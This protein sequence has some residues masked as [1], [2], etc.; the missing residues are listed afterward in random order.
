VRRLA[1]TIAA[2]LIAA[3]PA[4]A[5]WN[6]DGPGDVLA[7]RPD[8]KLL[9]YAGAG[10]GLAAPQAIGGDG[11]AALTAVMMPG[12][13]SG[14]GQPDVL[15]RTPQGEL[16]MYRG[17]GKGGWAGGIAQTVG[18]GWG[19]FTALVA[20]GD[21]SGDGLPDVL[22]RHSD[23][24][25]SMYRGDGDGGWITGKAEQIGTSWHNFAAVLPGGDFSGDGKPDVLVVGG[26]GVLLMYRGNGAGGWVTGKSEQIG[27]SGWGAFTALA[28][29]G[30]FSGDGKP[31]VL[32]RTSEGALLL[33]RGNGAGGWVSPFGEP[34]SSGWNGLTFLTLV[35]TTPAA[36]APPGPEPVPPPAVPVPDGNVSLTAGIRCTPPGGLLRVSLKVRKRSGRPA[37]KVQRI[38]FFVRGGPRR[39]DRKRPYTVRLR[40]H[41]PA[42]QKGRV[43]A[44]VFFKRAGSKTLR[45]KT[46]SRRYVMCG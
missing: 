14:D 3:A 7:V 29:G 17:D 15:V 1:L 11:W 33:Y 31:D 22:A 44:R 34:I 42:A 36:P 35:P 46:V 4:Q 30:D 16:Q 25:L 27:G 20:P 38:V 24:T 12:D 32:A 13:F 10:S 6:G 40:M 28:S 43:Y 26:D 45:T 37:P 18:A 41:R 21:F 8:G 19:P 5:D 2:L 9:F 39:T 23:G